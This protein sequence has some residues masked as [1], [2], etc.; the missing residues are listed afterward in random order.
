MLCRVTDSAPRM[1]A[2]AY[3]DLFSKF[4]LPAAG[5]HASAVRLHFCR[6]VIESCGGEIGCEPGEDER[7]QFLDSPA[8][9]GREMKTLVLIDNDPLSRALLSQCLV[10]GGWR[11]FEADNGEAGLEARAGTSAARGPLRFAHAEGQRLQG[12]PAHPRRGAAEENARRAHRREPFRERSRYRARGRRGRLFG[13]T[14][15]ARRSARH[16]GAGGRF[17]T[18]KRRQPRGLGWTGADPILGRARFH[19][20]ARHETAVF[21][22]N[23]SCVEVRVGSEV[24]ILD[25]GSGIRGLGQGAH[26]RSERRS[27]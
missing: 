17:R 26:A 16:A 5:S 24:I 19:S 15:H 21:G 12:L 8:E 27:R 22:G 2:E 6:I 11:V 7:Q 18:A 3:D 13:Q 20:H 4:G 23:T 14:D 1:S 25:A 9:A 10:G